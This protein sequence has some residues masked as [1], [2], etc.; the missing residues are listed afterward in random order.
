MLRSS[1]GRDAYC[2]AVDRARAYIRS[3]DIYQVNLAQRFDTAIEGDAWT[4]FQSLFSASPAPF[5][6]FLD[7]GDFQLASI[8]PELFL[9]FSGAHILTRPIKGTRPRSSA[10][11]GRSDCT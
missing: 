3:G 7:A 11:T 6:A 2:A 1:L 5:G 4:L 9:R 8:S 10:R